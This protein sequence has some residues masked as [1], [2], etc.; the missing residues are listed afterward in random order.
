MRRVV[1]HTL[2][3][4]LVGRQCTKYRTRKEI[5]LSLLHHQRRSGK[6]GDLGGLA[7][8][9]AH[10]RRRS[11]KAAGAGTR[12]WRAYLSTANRCM[13]KDPHRRGGPWVNAKGVQV[14]ANRRPI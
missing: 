3:I 2:A 11:R 7:G 1:W 6:G 13:P 14:A 8:A 12:Q 9:D 10:L 4:A 5:T